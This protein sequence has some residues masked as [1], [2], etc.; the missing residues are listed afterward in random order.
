M[1]PARTQTVDPWIRAPHAITLTRREPFAREPRT[2]RV[3]D[4]PISNQPPGT[5]RHA[6]ALCS[7]ITACATVPTAP[8]TG[9]APPPFTAEEIRDATP[10]G[11]VWTYEMRQL[12]QPPV[13]RVTRVVKSDEQGATFE[14]TSYNVGGEVLGETETSTSTWA[15]LVG[16]ATFPAEN[17]VIYEGVE[18][19][20][21]AGFY[22]AWRYEVREPG[23]TAQVKKF[24]FAKTRPGPPVLYEQLDDGKVMFRMELLEE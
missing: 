4:E 17:T 5:V 19:Q 22:D 9:H 2:G 8:P 3:D 11:T 24:Y 23:K 18:V 6:L 7:V 14:V 16:H 13:K 21:R 12:R 15:E 1:R 20:T 10:E